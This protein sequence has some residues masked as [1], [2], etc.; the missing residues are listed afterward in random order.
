VGRGRGWLIAAG[1]LLPLVWIPAVVTTLG[2]PPAVAPAPG[3]T[4]MPTGGPDASPIPPEP[5]SPFALA[6]GFPIHLPAESVRGVAFHEASMEGAMT[7]RPLGR[8][9][10]CRHPRFRPPRPP[11]GPFRYIVMDPRG[12]GSAPTSAVDVVVGRRTVVLA[13]VTGRV[14]VSRRYRLYDRYPDRRVAIVPD[15]ADGIEVVII[16]LRGVRL[17]PGE[18]VTA[19]VTPLGWARRFPFSSQVDRYVAGDHPHVHIEVVDVEARREAKRRERRR[20]EG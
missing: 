5:L 16:H 12:R 15:G 18:R 1:F 14:R 11:D 8:C 17:A 13:P 2:E 7:M 3:P 10:P 9:R 6:P 19:S 4:P 20:G